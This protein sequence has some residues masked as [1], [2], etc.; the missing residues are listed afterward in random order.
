VAS[1]FQETALISPVHIRVCGA[2]EVLV[3]ARAVPGDALSR[4][5]IRALLVLLAGSAAM[6][7]EREAVCDALWP[8]SD[9][10]TAR[11]RLYHTV[12]LLRRALSQEAGD[13]EWVG[14]SGGRVRLHPDVTSDALLMR[15]LALA[16]DPQA[17]ARWLMQQQGPL[18]PFAPWLPELP[19]VSALR[20]EIQSIWQEVIGHAV[21]N[22]AGF[23]DT[24]ARRRMLEHLLRLSPANEAIHCALMT[25]DLRAGRAHR[26][27]RQF[28]ICARMLAEHLG[29]RP[30]VQAIE[31]FRQ[32][33]AQLS[34]A[35]GAGAHA[36]PRRAHE[37]SVVGR[38]SQIEDIAAVL[39]DRARP[40]VTLV[41]IGG[42]GKSRI[43]REL[44]RQMVGELEDG[45]LWIDMKQ[46]FNAT[47]GA[48]GIL[49]RI[50]GRGRDSALLDGDDD[51]AVRSF[52]GL[53]V[54]DDA[55]WC[56][57]LSSVVAAVAA[58]APAARWLVTS[59]RPIGLDG[60]RCIPILPLPVPPE[61]ATPA[62]LRANP[63]MQLLLRRAFPVEKLDESRLA[64]IGELVRRLD[65]LPLALELAAT[66]LPLR[67]AAELC[68]EL[69]H[70]LRPL[71]SGPI[72]FEGHQQ[73]MSMTLDHTV[74]G[75]SAHALICYQVAAVPAGDF[76]LAL[77]ARLAPSLARSADLASLVEEIEQ[78]GIIRSV[79]DESLP[80]RWRMGHLARLHA[81]QK[82]RQSGLD[83]ELK[84]RHLAWISQALSADMART[85]VL[86]MDVENL[87]DRLQS[88]VVDALRYAEKVRPALLPWVASRV[89]GYW[90]L[91]G[92]FG[93]GQRWLER[94]CTEALKLPAAT[95]Y[96]LLARLKI[97]QAS[98]RLLQ[99]HVVEARSLSMDALDAARA[100]G[101][102]SLI[103]EAANIVVRA[104]IHSGRLVEAIEE[105]SGWIG[106][107]GHVGDP[108]ARPLRQS[109]RIARARSGN[110]RS[111]RTSPRDVHGQGG[112][113]LPGMGASA[114]ESL[115]TITDEWDEC[116]RLRSWPAS[117]ELSNR[118]LRDARVAQVAHLRVVAETM[119]ARSARAVDRLP[120][121]LQAAESATDHGRRAGLW[122][123]SAASALVAAD[124]LIR[125]GEL[126]RAE[127]IL[128]DTATVVMDPSNGVP[129]QANWHAAAGLLALARGKAADAADRLLAIASEARSFEDIQILVAATEL[130]IVICASRGHVERASRLNGL[131]ACLDQPGIA[132]R[133]PLEQR[134]LRQQLRESDVEQV[135]T[136]ISA[137]QAI[138]ELIQQLGSLALVLASARGDP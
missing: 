80:R 84:D 47:R 21:G 122:T 123:L 99:S 70:D 82:A 40:V 90:N 104:L 29:L 63:A 41:G 55:E 53:L 49:E 45:V 3:G 87:L 91:R 52:S 10:S 19:V 74:A 38:G 137:D 101:D 96:P 109:L 105:A 69:D 68:A 130:G 46:G 111:T 119:A 79:A 77:L 12:M 112:T 50:R 120:E 135:V 121:A 76:D 9:P 115:W 83:L 138:S 56:H 136:E 88:E 34:S 22:A 39:S 128:S 16:A 113:A 75:L 59:I 23:D 126:E 133:V 98:M 25:L 71:D 4:W 33:E 93:R 97:Q 26:V 17:S 28:E 85:D 42:V 57:D 106:K 13:Q 18:Q 30:S 15:R 67:T 48:M 37:L 92:H 107:V 35:G 94:A 32:A 54:V 20:V 11:N 65:G 51:A 61:G 6:S 89:G 114:L 132:P 125:I 60:E 127:R 116:Y 24:P 58:A 64:E 117:L 7:V 118:S 134:W 27:L 95:R 131:L 108:L 44:A 103:A 8:D 100:T 86:P 36:A 43:A 1:F 14:V 5:H 78:L 81:A 72:D 2:L 102:A 31:L 110:A 66:R 124:I 62:Q 129:L 73:T